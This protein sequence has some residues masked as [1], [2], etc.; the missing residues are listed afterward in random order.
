MRH[1]LDTLESDLVPLIQSIKAEFAAMPG[2]SLT[3]SQAQRLWSLEPT[4]CHRVL[5]ALTDAGFLVERPSGGYALTA[6][7]CHSLLQH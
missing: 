7:A 3:P 4:V 2:L 1:H 5:D 6:G